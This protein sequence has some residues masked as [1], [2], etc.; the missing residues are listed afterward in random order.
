[1]PRPVVHPA[2]GRETL[3]TGL[4]APELAVATFGVEAH[5]RAMV[6]MTVTGFRPL[7]GIIVTLWWAR[8]DYEVWDSGNGVE[9]VSGGDR[10]SPPRL[11]LSVVA[12][13]YLRGVAVALVG[14]FW[15][16]LL[17]TGPAIR[18]IMRLLAVTAGDAAQGRIT[19][20]DEV[21]GKINVDG[22]LALFVFGGILPA[23]LSGAIYVLVRRWLPSGLLTGI[24]FGALHLVFAA[25]RIDPLRPG[26]PDFDLV[27]PGWLAVATFGVAAILHGMAVVAIANRY[28]HAIPPAAAPAPHGS[29]P[30]CPSFFRPCWSCCSSPS[31]SRRPGSSLPWSPHKSAWSSGPFAVA[32]RFLR[33]A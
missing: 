1:M 16:G 4:A 33:D 12:L 11:P 27:G 31:W 26:N 18:L 6:L 7:V 19:E 15:A 25:T 2:G 3:P 13:R 5:Y 14:G 30:R 23:M 22:T 29:G 32:P 24:T 20:A 8:T 21:V 17:V 28:S 9:P 10:T